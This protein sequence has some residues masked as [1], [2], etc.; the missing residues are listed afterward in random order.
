MTNSVRGSV[1]MA[2]HVRISVL[3]RQRPYFVDVDNGY[4]MA[5]AE[6]IDCL[7]KEI[8]LVLPEK[9]DLIVLPEAC[10]RPIN[11]PVN[12]R[13][14]YFLERG[15]KILDF[16]RDIAKSNACNIAYSTVRN[17]PDGTFRNST[18]MINRKGKIDGIYNK[19]HIVHGE[20]T[21]NDIYCGTNA[22]IIECD[23]GKVGCVICFDLN[24]EPIRRKYEKQRPEMII[25][26]S[27]YH[28]GIMQNYWAYACRTY[29]VSAFGYGESTI[30]SPVGETVG[31]SS[32][33]YSYFTR[34]INLDYAVVHLDYNGIKLRKMKEK[35]GC[36]VTI[37][38][39]S[40]LGAVLVT[41]EVDNVSA[42]DMI[43]EFDVEL[44]D[45]YFNRSLIFHDENRGDDFAD[46]YN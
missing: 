15:E 44:L 42:M 10:D 13:K 39:P 35:Y 16:Y 5:V 14:Q 31:R 9:P 41:S 6:M 32:S 12:D 1:F 27:N 8:D 3:G 19:H 22:P 20:K 33:Y 38:D 2:R 40:H 43:K 21:N 4:D 7:K 36:G 45:D 24:F 29:F 11:L 26:C 25:A 17:V 34:T 23:F 28:G 18:M 37:H 30:V 46:Q